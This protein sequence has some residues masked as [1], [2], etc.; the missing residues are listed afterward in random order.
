VEVASGVCLSVER[1]GVMLIKVWENNQ[2]SS[3]KAIKLPL[4]HS[5]L[6]P[7]M[8]V[9]LISTKSIFRYEGIRTYFNDELKMILPNGNIVRF[10]ETQRNYTLAF[11]DDTAPIIAVACHAFTRSNPLPLNWDLAHSRLVHFSPERILASENFVSNFDYSK[12]RSGARSQPPCLACVRGS[13][14]GHRHRSREKGKFTRFAQ[15]VYSDSCAMPTSTPF[16]FCE[17][18]IFYDACCK[19][20]AVYFGKTTTTEEMISI[21]EQYVVDFKQYMPKGHVEEFY[22]DGG[23]EFKG[24]ALDDFCREMSTRRRFIA[25]WNPWMNVSE[26]G[27]RIIGQQ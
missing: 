5:L 20:I 26:T 27:W 21:F 23:P 4:K 24:A 14:R 13:F 2:T 25:P 3:K 11:C 9:T 15:R 16:G 17:M 12:L 1:T 6:V 8:P 10:V 19:H 18:Y 22:A 7:G